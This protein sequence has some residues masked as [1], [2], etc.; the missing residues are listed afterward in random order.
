M[1]A[2]EGT[3]IR[4]DIVV[5]ARPETDSPSEAPPPAVIWRAETGGRY[6]SCQNLSTGALAGFWYYG[7]SII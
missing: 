5:I 1:S 7:A 3:S 6:L 2:L 4:F